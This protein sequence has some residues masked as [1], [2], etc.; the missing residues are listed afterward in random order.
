[1]IFVSWEEAPPE[2]GRGKRPLNAQPS[3]KPTRRYGSRKSGVLRLRPSRL[4]FSVSFAC[5]DSPF[6]EQSWS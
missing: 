6:R 2:A 3:R 1:M 5:W 4:R